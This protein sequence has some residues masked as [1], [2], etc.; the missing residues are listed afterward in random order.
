[1]TVAISQFTPSRRDS[2][3]RRLRA[4]NRVLAVAAVVLTLVLAELAAHGFH[5]HARKLR[6]EVDAAALGPA[7]RI[8]RRDQAPRLRARRRDSTRHGTATQPTTSGPRHSRRAAPPRRHRSPRNPPVRQRLSRLRPRRV[9]RRPCRADR[10]HRRDQ[11]DRRHGRPRDL[12]G[13]GHERGAAARH[14]G[15][16]P[17]GRRQACRGARARRHRRRRQPVSP[18]L[19]AVPRQPGRWQLGADRIAAARRDR[20][21]DPSGAG[22]GRSR[23]PDAGARPDRARL[24]PRLARARRRRRRTRRPRPSPDGTRTPRGLAAGGARRR[25]SQRPLPAG[26]DARPRS[27][28][29]GT[30]RRPRG[31]RGGRGRR[32]GRAGGARRRHRRPRARSGGRAGGFT[33]PTITGPAPTPPGR[34]C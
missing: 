18:R 28:R 11:S 5:G 10:E 2:G 12:G 1:M 31:S 19:R 15:S 14:V 30:G 9:R 6:R 21:R 23:G 32:R 7:D 4:A 3:L 27:D 25:P 24:R 33:S 20:A 13:A 8:A 34:R 17:P 29:Q 16:V 26:R 22:L